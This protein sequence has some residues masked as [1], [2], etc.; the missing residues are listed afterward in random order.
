MNDVVVPAE[1]YR[2]SGGEP[3]P[4]ARVIARRSPGILRWQ[5]MFLIWDSGAYRPMGDDEARALAYAELERFAEK[6]TRTRVTD[7]L[8][9]LRAVTHVSDSIEPSVYL[10]SR[11]QVPRGVI[12]LRNGILD[13]KT[14]ELHAPSPD[15]FTL[16]AL[17][18]DFDL[19]ADCPNWRRFL[20]DIWPNDHESIQTIQEIFGYLIAGTTEQQ[21]IFLIIGPKRSGKGTILR[22][23]TA[24]LGR[25]NV[26][27]PTL[28]SLSEQFG[29]Q[30]LIG[31]LAALVSDAR[32]S[33]RADQQ[34]IA[35]RL[36]SISGEDYLSI[37]RKH[38]G[39][40]TAQLHSRFVLATNELPRLHDA[41]GALASRFI[42]LV[43]ERSW[44]GQEDH[45]LTDR[46]LSELPGILNWSMHGYRRLHNRGHFEIPTNARDAMDELADLG[47]PISSFLRDRCVVEPGA[48][49]DVSAL[50]Q[51]WRDWC[52]D[53]GR[54]HPGTEQSFGRDLRAAVPTL[55]N[56]RV[57]RNGQR[58]RV[59]QGIRLITEDLASQW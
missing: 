42:P 52:Q 27:A 37:P 15:L 17:P 48:E 54:D 5:Q 25:Q 57:R 55:G 39:D 10:S 16:A 2:E 19:T 21:K 38:L 49:V 34:Q 43:M 6:A 8:D 53:H 11:E 56:S 32:L 28:G 44:F 35:E 26:A 14:A 59:Y 4:L 9:A 18:V 46:L 1:H 41:S 36:L 30:S 51:A 58:R 20:E 12:A 7:V 45:G 23:L 24:L 22:I 33:G 31:K 47:S 40:F 13:L 50:Y 3:L 29:L